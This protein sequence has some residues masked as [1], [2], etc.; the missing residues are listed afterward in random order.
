MDV[1]LDR[2]QLNLE[3]GGD[4]LVR[5]ALV[6]QPHDLHLARR[7][8]YHLICGV[9][10]LFPSKLANATEQ[11]TRDSRWAHQLVVHHAFEDRHK[12]RERSLTRYVPRRPGLRATN[13]DLLAVGDGEDDYPRFRYG[14]PDPPELPGSPRRAYVQQQHIGPSGD[15]LLDSPQN[16]GRRPQD[17]DASVPPEHPDEPFAIK[18]G[19]SDNHNPNRQMSLIPRPSLCAHEPCSRTGWL[20]YANLRSPI[21]RDQSASMHE[22]TAELVH[23][24]GHLRP[25]LLKD[26]QTDNSKRVYANSYD[27]GRQL[28]PLATLCRAFDGVSPSPAGA[29]DEKRYRCFTGAGRLAVVS[30]GAAIAFGAVIGLALGILV[31][32]TTDIPLAPEIGVAVGAVVGWLSRSEDG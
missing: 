19:P 6:D 28:Q 17:L 20:I 23:A 21:N 2:R 3:P 31:S 8:P 15:G 25:K 11:R 24:Q 16:I 30:V 12:L 27:F 5:K 1:V 32:V 29:S 9:G 13:H 7:E 4:L 10:I 22:R 14:I 26:Q 18:P